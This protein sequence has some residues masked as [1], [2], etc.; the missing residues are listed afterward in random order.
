MP[1]CEA[2]APPVATAPKRPRMQRP[3]LSRRE[4]IVRIALINAVTLG[5]LVLTAELGFRLLWSPKYWVGCDR[6]LIGSGWTEAGKKWWPQTTYHIQSDE[7]RAQFR[8]NDRGYRARTETPKTSDRPYRVAFVGDSFTEGMQVGVEQTFCARI[9]RGLKGLAPGRDVVCENFGVADTGLFEYWH[10]MIHDVLKSEPP[11]AVVL[12]I[13][14]GNDF[15]AEFPDAGFGPDG[16]PHREF[17]HGPSWGRHI[18]TW[19][20][21]HSKLGSYVVRSVFFTARG[22]HP[23]TLQ[24]PWFWWTDPTAAARLAR[25]TGVRRSRAVLEAIAAECRQ[26]GSRLCILVVGPLKTYSAWNGQSPLARIVADWGIDVPVIDVA[27]TA[28]ARPDWWTLLFARDGHLNESGHAFV[29]AEATPPLRAALA[30]GGRV[31][32]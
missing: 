2:E 16:R 6:W 12:C 18:M 26:R 23:P 30:P 20:N 27:V 5:I 22:L 15:V 8:T 31:V 3:A 9:E 32:R 19:V 29:A 14:P 11:D 10:R 28:R 21:L 1:V 13:F 25:E 4:W 7:F 24:A 17:F